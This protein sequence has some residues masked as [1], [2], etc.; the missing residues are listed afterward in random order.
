M[1]DLALLMLL[2]KFKKRLNKVDSR[3]AKVYKDGERGPQGPQG[4]QGIKGEGTQGPKGEQGSQGP[5]GPQGANGS[6]GSSGVDGSDGEDGVSIVDAEFAADGDLVFTLSD[7]SELSVEMPLDSGGEKSNIFIS[8]G[9]G[10]NSGGSG[11]GSGIEGNI[12]SIIESLDPRYIKKAGD[13]G[14]QSLYWTKDESIGTDGVNLFTLRP[15]AVDYVGDYTEDDHV[16][17]KKN[18]DDAIAIIQPPDGFLGEAPMNG[19]RYVRRNGVWEALLPITSSTAANTIVS[20]NSNSDSSFNQV[21]ADKGNFGGA[22]QLRPFSVYGTGTNG[23]LSLQGG[24]DNDNPGIEMTTDSNV[25]RVLQRIARAGTDGTELQVWTQQDGAGIHM[26]FVFGE[27]G[28]FFLRPSGSSTNVVNDAGFRNQTG[29]LEFRNDE[30]EWTP[31]DTAGDQGPEGPQGQRAPSPA[32][33][34]RQRPPLRRAAA[35]GRAEG[36]VSQGIL[37]T[38]PHAARILGKGQGRPPGAQGIERPHPD[39]ERVPQGELSEGR[40][41]VLRRQHGEAQAGDDAILQ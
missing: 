16:A 25:T 10:G 7:G 41:P 24:S 31:F 32:Q 3:T 9:G 21:N 26:P 14:I 37:A 8:Q 23:R 28:E 11:G 27:G 35:T 39:G 2:E 36:R 17:T 34:S 6:D 30:G 13:T 18:V 19:K 20:R 5:Q 22:Q 38:G 40:R 4:P 29:T 1:D 15:S 33:V 12:D